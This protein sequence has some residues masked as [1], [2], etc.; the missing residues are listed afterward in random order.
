ENSPQ[1]QRGIQ[2]LTGV[3][4]GH[5]KNALHYTLLIPREEVGIRNFCL[6]AIGLAVLTLRKINRHL[7]YTDGN[8]VKISRVTVRGTVLVSR[9]AVRHNRLLKLL[10]A[11]AGSGLPRTPISAG[12][13]PAQDGAGALDRAV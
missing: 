4:H 5:L 13:S 10:F 1:F 12:S 3:A 8:Q 6:W 2:R 9:L 11:A 7:D